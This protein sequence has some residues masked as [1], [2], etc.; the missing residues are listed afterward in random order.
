M[1]RRDQ[2][3]SVHQRDNKQNLLHLVYQIILVNLYRILE[4]T[5]F[6]IEQ[7]I[8]HIVRN[9]LIHEA[10][11]SSDPWKLVE[12]GKR[13]ITVLMQA[14]RVDKVQDAC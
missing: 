12:N 3:I 9:W 6:I 2:F 14:L 10:D 11:Q 1:C 8:C 7:D 13:K 4:Q 5:P